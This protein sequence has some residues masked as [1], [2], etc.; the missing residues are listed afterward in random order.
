MTFLTAVASLGVALG[1][2]LLVGMEREQS[3]SDRDSE[4]RR[5]GGFR[6]FPM[7]ALTG[8]VCGLLVPSLGWV[9]P[10]VLTAALGAVFT[11]LV[12]IEVLQGSGRGITTEVAG[13]AVF[14]LGLLAGVPLDGLEAT[15]RWALVA[16]LGTAV[17][18]LLTYRSPLRAFAS[19]VRG[20]QL[21]LVVQV[22]VLLFVVLPLLRSCG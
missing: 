10:A 2:G 18:G 5:F 22:G 14:L 9:L 16:A 11:A 1:V 13:M 12:S 19:K 20:K 3:Q 17:M 4:D 21:R 8:A 15:W 6:T 7:L